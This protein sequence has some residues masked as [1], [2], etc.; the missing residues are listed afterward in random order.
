MKN[1]LV[2][3]KE[4]IEILKRHKL[5]VEQTKNNSQEIIRAGFTAGCFGQ[6]GNDRYWG[7]IESPKGSGNYVFQKSTNDATMKSQ[8]YVVVRIKPD[9]TFYYVK[10]GQNGLPSEFTQPRALLNPC[11]AMANFGK[12]TED[13]VNNEYLIAQYKKDKW[14]TPEELRTQSVDIRELSNNTIWQSVTV[15]NVKLYK[16]VGT[17]TGTMDDKEEVRKQWVEKLR[18]DGY[19][20]NP[21]DTE[22]DN[23]QYVELSKI[24]YS[25]LPSGLFPTSQLVYLDP[26]KTDPKI[27]QDKQENESMDRKGCKETIE[28][29]YNEFNR[30]KGRQITNRGLIQRMKDQA[31]FC[32]NEFEGKWGI[33]GGKFDEMIKVLSGRTNRG[34]SS[35]GDDSMFRLQ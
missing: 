11:P 27:L 6:K 3:E 32:K 26:S 33:G 30:T 31:Q 18:K 13:Q 29:F 23:Y 9:N 4:R 17:A 5:L 14:A 24:N 19:I 21:T 25:G 15:G 1:F 16:K 28:R 2:E 8:G 10:P 7:I 22:K 12:K 34:P 35:S 20:V